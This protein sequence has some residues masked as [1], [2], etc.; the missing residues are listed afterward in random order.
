VDIRFLVAA[1]LPWASGL[2]VGYFG[3]TTVISRG[4]LHDA[5]QLPGLVALVEGKPVGLV[6]YRFA[7]D[8]C[9]VV[10]IAAAQRRRG[11]GTALLAAARDV[12]QQAGCR[13]LWLVT[14]NDNRSAQAFYEAQGM[15]LVTIHRGAVTQA[16]VLKPEIPWTGENGVLI[17]DEIEYEFILDWV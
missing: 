3:S 17:E 11:I 16:R 2:I 15:R 4:V 9:E 8:D 5:L 7:A 6:Q 12:A 13:R 10:L 14:T 1:D